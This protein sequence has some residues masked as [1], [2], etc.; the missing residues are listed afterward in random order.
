MI[1]DILAE[2]TL[3]KLGQGA[4]ELSLDKQI[5]YSGKWLIF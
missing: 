4:K 5:Q 2:R 3:T 1:G